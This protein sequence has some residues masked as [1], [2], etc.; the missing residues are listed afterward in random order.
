MGERD[1]GEPS[2]FYDFVELHPRLVSEMGSL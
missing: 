1:S 2:V